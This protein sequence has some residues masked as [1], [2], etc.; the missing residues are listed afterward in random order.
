MKRRIKKQK[1]SRL[2]LVFSTI[3]LILII[4]FFVNMTI[5]KEKQEDITNFNECVQ[6]GNLVMESYPRQCRTA[7]G[8]LFVEELTIGE[9]CRNLYGGNW[10]LEHN[11]CENIREEQCFLLGGEFNECASACRHDISAEFCIMACV[12][13]CKL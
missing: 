8:K 13:V 4:L 10:L 3:T 5:F 12:P 6:R 2:V 11:E 1:L 7:E 9:S